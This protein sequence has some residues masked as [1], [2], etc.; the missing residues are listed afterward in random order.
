MVSSNSQVPSAISK[1]EFPQAKSIVVSGDIHGDFAQLVYKCCVQYSMKDTLIIVAGDCGFGFYKFGS[2][3]YVYQKCRDKLSKANNRL[4]FVRGNH[5]NPAYFEEGVVKHK[6]WMTIPDY[7]VIKACGHSIL[8]VGGA[9]SIDRLYRIMSERWHPLETD[10]PLAP[11]VYWPNEQPYY[12]ELKLDAIDEKFAIDTVITHTSPSFCELTSHQGLYEW[13]IRDE[14]LIDDVKNERKVMD[15]LHTYLYAKNHPLRYW[16]YGHYHQS[17]H[18]EI[19]G[20]KYNM[21]DIMELREI[22]VDDE[23]NNT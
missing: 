4:A 23:D 17:W 21:L 11:N 13:A 22:P 15:N 10:E 3:E 5:D 19:D 16:F 7:S 8:C 1:L 2:Y 14:N 12:D 9:T 18:S 6:R 20:V